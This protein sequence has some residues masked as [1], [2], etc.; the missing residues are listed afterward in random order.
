MF[1]QQGGSKIYTDNNS[2]AALQKSAGN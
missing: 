2:T 1:Y